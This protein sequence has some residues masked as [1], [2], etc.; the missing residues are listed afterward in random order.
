MAFFLFLGSQELLE[1]LVL[2]EYE[3]RS[4]PTASEAEAL[5]KTEDFSFILLDT[6]DA[7]AR[8]LLALP[9]ALPL[10]VLAAPP[11]DPEVYRRFAERQII[12][13][14]D[15]ASL[16]ASL[17]KSL[18]LMPS[19][20]AGRLDLPELVQLKNKALSH[21]YH[22][23]Q[24]PVTALE[25]YLEILR[26]DRL[27][28]ESVQQI[29]SQLGNCVTRLRYYFHSLHLLSLVSADS[30]KLKPRP[31]QFHQLIREFQRDF[32]QQR[33][34]Y[35]VEGEY[36]L[37]AQEDLVLADP[38]FVLH[39]LSVLVDL[40]LRTSLESGRVVSLQTSNLSI[41]RLDAHSQ[42]ELDANQHRASFLPEARFSQYLQVSF[43]FRGVGPQLHQALLFTLK[44][45]S[46]RPESLDPETLLG[47]YLV[48]RLLRACQSWL[49]FESQPGSGLLLSFVLP[50]HHLPRP[51]A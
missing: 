49:Y 3:L 22:Q 14:V 32:Q 36:Q 37:E 31:F 2:P 5:L 21:L 50:V 23:L 28:E 25:G 15:P 33:A 9:L 19:P 34:I 45:G 10:F 17:E 39:L 41:E 44:P 20:A 42:L 47:A 11:Y 29:L 6:Q 26:S 18:V 27:P 48:E 1:Q 16:P 38:H 12:D 43:Q 4:V 30:Y 7:E 35:A 46:E 13:L 51:Q 24:G 8:Q 40:A